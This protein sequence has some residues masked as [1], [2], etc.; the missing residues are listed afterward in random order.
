MI[1][2]KNKDWRE[3]HSDRLSEREKEEL[4]QEWRDYGRAPLAPKLED[5]HHANFNGMMDIVVHSLNGK[6]MDKK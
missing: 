2:R 4:I 3:D 1:V 6:T 5:N